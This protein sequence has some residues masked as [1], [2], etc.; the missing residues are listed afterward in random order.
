MDFYLDDET[1]MKW[2]AMIT[3]GW[4]GAGGRGLAGRVCVLI[5]KTMGFVLPVPAWEL[6]CAPKAV[7]RRSPCSNWCRTALL[8]PSLPSPPRPAACPC[9]R[10]AAA[11]DRR[12]RRLSL[13]GR[14]LAAHLPLCLHLSAGVP[15]R[16]PLLPGCGRQPVCL[17]PR[18]G[19]PPRR[20]A[21]AARRRAHGG[22]P[23]VG[24]W[25]G[26]WMG[27]WVGGLTEGVGRAAGWGVQ[28]ASAAVCGAF[29]A[30]CKLADRSPAPTCCPLQLLA[31]PHRGL[32]PRQRPPRLRDH[33][34]AL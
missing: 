34:A 17:H 28:A 12:R 25:V 24:G 9:C 13:P 15:H 8:I 1:R 21:Q 10:D 27:E 11:G 7:L 2:D 30:R 6:S 5:H 32:P 18:A 33:A 4:V 14:A 3:G 29:A 23:Q 22:I 31:Q 20:A 16:P 19:G 26:E